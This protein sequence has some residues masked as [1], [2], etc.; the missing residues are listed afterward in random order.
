M[1]LALCGV[2]VLEMKFEDGTGFNCAGPCDFGYLREWRRAAGEEVFVS[3]AWG[4]HLGE[5]RAWYGLGSG[6]WGRAG[7]RETT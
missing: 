2:W 3:V 4:C 5:I 1:E 6:S 7:G